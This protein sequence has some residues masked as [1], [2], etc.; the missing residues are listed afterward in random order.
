MTFLAKVIRATMIPLTHRWFWACLLRLLIG[1]MVT[2]PDTAPAHTDFSAGKT[3]EQLFGSD[4][5]GC[6]RSPYGLAHGRNA[7]TLTGFLR[8]HYT[9]KAQSAVLL[10]SY[11]TRPRAA[12]SRVRPTENSFLKIIWAIWR[13]V[14]TTS[15]WLIGQLGKLLHA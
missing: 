1:A 13:K 7:R 14:S 15:W 5:S 10:A 11:L 9:T 12:N 6:H 4:C 8:E 2:L 3:P